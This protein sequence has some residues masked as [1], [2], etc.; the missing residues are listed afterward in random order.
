MNKFFPSKDFFH[1][2]FIDSLFVYL[3]NLLICTLML[4]AGYHGHLNPPDWLSGTWLARSWGFPLM[5]IGI[6]LLLLNLIDYFF[7]ISE[8]KV[9]LATQIIFLA[10]HV[11]VSIRLLIVIVEFR[12]Q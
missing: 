8:F 7:K 5:V 4:A 1:E 12:L 6:I 10:I 11:F 3:R 9:S 2:G